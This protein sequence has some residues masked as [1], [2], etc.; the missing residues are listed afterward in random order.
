MGLDPLSGDSPRAVPEA[1]AD[2][3]PLGD[4]LHV[5][6]GQPPVSGALG[7]LTFG[8]RPLPANR[9]NASSRDFRLGRLREMLDV[10]AGDYDVRA[11]SADG[12]ALDESHE[13]LADA[14]MSDRVRRIAIVG[15]FTGVRGP[16]GGA[17]I[18][19]QSA[20]TRLAQTAIRGGKEVMYSM[21]PDSSDRVAIQS[22]LTGGF[23][24]GKQPPAPGSDE[25]LDSRSRGTALLARLWGDSSLPDL[26]VVIQDKQR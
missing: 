8:V 5:P 24:A 10:I 3:S 11:C 12:C 7:L 16:I 13:V 26:L 15:A 14:L 25:S 1:G 9:Q 19:V 18:E 4:S 17:G 2:D 21:T 6:S 22:L 20:I 23:A